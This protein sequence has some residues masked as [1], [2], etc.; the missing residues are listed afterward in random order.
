MLS[1]S[2]LSTVLERAIPIVVLAILLFYIYVELWYAPYLGFNFSASS[3]EIALMSA[4]SDV[5]GVLRQGDSILRVGDV[6]WEQYSTNMRQVLFDPVG[7]GN[8]VNIEI[9]RNGEK[10]SIKWQIQPTSLTEVIDRVVNA[11]WLGLF[12]W[13]T[14]T[15]TV[16]LVRPKDARW[17]LLIAFYFLTAI[18]LVI[19]NNSRWR[20]WDSAILLRITIWLS[21]P[22]YLH[23]HWIFPHELRKLP[24]T[25]GHGLYSLCGVLAVAEWFQWLPITSYFL[26]F[27]TAVL[28]STCLLFIHYWLCPEQ[29]NAIRLILVATF[30]ALVPVSL[31][32]FALSRHSFPWYGTVGL[33]G[34]LP[35]PGAYFYS[36]YRKQLGEIELRTNRLVALYLFLLVMMAITTMIAGVISTQRG[37]SPF[38]VISIMTVAL[39]S[40][41]FTFFVFPT[42]QR[43]VES[44]ILGIP[45]APPQLVERYSSHIATTLNTMDLVRLLRDEIPDLL[46]IRQSAL[47]QM[48]SDSAI[49]LVYA[50]GIEEQNLSFNLDKHSEWTRLTLP[51]ILG[52]R[53]VG[54]WLIGK[55]DPDDYFAPNE[56][57]VLQVL[58]NQV[59]A[60]LVNIEQTEQLRAIYRANIDRNEA[61]RIHLAYILHDE[62]LQR[63]ATLAL[64]VD[65]TDSHEATTQFDKAYQQVTEQIRQLI[66]GLRPA[67][68]TYGLGAALE[69]YI[70][71]LAERAEKHISIIYMVSSDAMS[72]YAPDIEEYLFR[73]VQQAC[74][75]A[76]RHAHANYIRVSG[77][78]TSDQV[79]LAIEDD[80]VGFA[81]SG[82]LDLPS[83]LANRHFGLVGMYERSVILSADLQIDSAIGQGTKVQI[84]WRSNTK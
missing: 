17:R 28:G 57:S 37:Y 33:L 55:R 49:T 61:E 35:I 1:T 69:E 38:T 82:Q 47:L 54:I 48:T 59:A 12:F 77:E 24:R 29:R 66:T 75:N 16:L 56:V 10:Q 65:Q 60:S 46:L 81:I 67:M 41:T 13:L 72:R 44:H 22:V 3:G 4:K 39:I 8:Y 11:W 50:K 45:P 21:V 7:V 83:L 79:R 2:K 36:A 30:L 58:A 70:E 43:L 14:G 9:Q 80:G 18:W 26:G 63:M 25:I 19:G 76:Y 31:I 68:L 23:L 51:L 78:I 34:L 42:F 74:E 40:S 73:I 20:F 15:L 62:I 52:N 84:L 5:T 64:S 71:S 53:R 27:L 6:T 32:S